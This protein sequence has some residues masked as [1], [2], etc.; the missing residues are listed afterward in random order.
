MMNAT[1]TMAIDTFMNADI[2]PGLLFEII[3]VIHARDSVQCQI[4]PHVMPPL[5]LKVVQ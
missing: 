1:A 3:F 5:I 4:Y 2:E